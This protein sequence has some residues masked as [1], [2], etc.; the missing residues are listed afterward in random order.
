MNTPNKQNPW[1]HSDLL[2]KRIGHLTVVRKVGSNGVHIEWEAKCDCGNTI[3]R[4]VKNLNRLVTCSKQCPIHRANI[5]KKRQTHGMTKHPAYGIWRSMI[6]RCRL[7]SHQA[8]HNYGGR[9]IKV[10][11]E[12]QKDF[13][14]FWA[15]MGPTYKKGLTLDRI[16]NNG[17]YHK[18]NCRWVTPQVQA[19]NTRL[20][21][22]PAWA[23]DAANKNGIKR[24]TLYYRIARG[25]PLE[26]ACTAK[27]DVTQRFTTS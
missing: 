22:T 5:S 1:K 27:P 20:S 12:W 10:C 21:V 24:S 11:P 26:V 9:G 16:D 19:R 13:L 15:D 3:V 8:W 17:G 7:P 23:L 18:S 25:V 6:D 2:G 4:T 14:D